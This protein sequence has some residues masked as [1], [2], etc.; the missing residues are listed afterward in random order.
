MHLARLLVLAMLL[1]GPA[2]AQ[3]DLSELTLEELLGHTPGAMLKT[4]QDNPDRFVAEAAGVILGYG[5]ADGI[6]ATGLE[7]AVLA[8]RAQIRARELRR[9]LTA[10]LD[11]NFAIDATE[12]DIALR[13]AS[14]TMR[15]R[16]LGWHLEADRNADGVAGWDEI[17]GF[18]ARAAQKGFNDSRAEAI[19]RL[20]VFDLDQN[21]CVTVPEVRAAVTIL[22]EAA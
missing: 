9:L 18:A 3:S 19:R 14:A 13:A 17:R 10:D 12:L 16:L 22:G 7:Q 15:G 21:G 8:A 6:D 4:L 1:S 5:G 20:M 2:L 11:G